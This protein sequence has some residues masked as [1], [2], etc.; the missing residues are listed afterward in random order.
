[1]LSGAASSF[2]DG[3]SFS[4]NSDMSVK[5]V[6]ENN[7]TEIPVGYE[8]IYNSYSTQV[9]KYINKTYSSSPVSKIL[10]SFA[11]NGDY[12]SEY[13]IKDGNEITNPLFR[14][15]DEYAKYVLNLS[16]PVCAIGVYNN[17]TQILFANFPGS[18]NELCGDFVGTTELSTNEEYT[19]SAEA[20]GLPDGAV[21]S[22][23][24][25]TFD[26]Y[27]KISG[28]SLMIEPVKLYCD[29]TA[30]MVM[31]TI[32]PRNNSISQ[33]GFK[34]SVSN[35]LTNTIIKNIKI[36]KIITGE[37]DCVK[38]LY[39]SE[40][41]YTELKG[42]SSVWTKITSCKLAGI[43]DC[44]R[45]SGTDLAVN[46]EN[47]ARATDGNAVIWYNDLGGAKMGSMFTPVE[48]NGT[49]SAMGGLEYGKVTKQRD[50]TV[51]TYA[52]YNSDGVFVKTTQNINRGNE[53]KICTT[54]QD[55]YGRT[56]RS[57][58]NKGVVTTYG[59]DEYGR[60]T[61]S[62]TT[63]GSAGTV[64]STCA[65]TG[66]V[67][68][69]YTVTETDG[70]GYSTV[71]KYDYA[72]GNVISVTD[73]NGN[74]IE[75]DYDSQQRLKEVAGRS[76]NVVNKNQ[77]QYTKDYISI[78]QH[79]GATYGITQTNGRVTSIML[80]GAT[81][82][83][84]DDRY[85]TEGYI[86]KT[87]GSQTQCIYYDKFGREI[88][89]KWSDGEWQTKI[90]GEITDE[91]SGITS[92]TDGSLNVTTASKLRK[93]L[94]GSENRVYN[95]NIDGTLSE[96]VYSNGD[97]Y[98]VTYDGYGRKSG[99]SYACDGT[100]SYGYAYENGDMQVTDKV[101]QV[102]IT[103]NGYFGAADYTYDALERLT[104]VKYRAALLANN[105]IE[106][107]YEY[108]A[109]SPE[110][111]ATERFY[112]NGALKTANSVVYDKNG[113]ITYYGATKY[114]YDTLNR[115]IREDNPTL[116]KSYVYAY[117][118]GGNI[119]SKK[120]YAYTTG[121]LGSA[122]KTSTYTY[123][124]TTHKDRLTSWAGKS[125]AYDTAGN[126]TTYKGESMTWKSG[127]L[128]VS[129]TKGGK[130]VEYAYDGEGIRKTKTVPSGNGFAEKY[131]YKYINDK[132]VEEK[133]QLMLNDSVLLTVK[134]QFMYAGDEVIGV[135]Y[136][137]KV[138][139]Y[140][141]NLQGDVIGIYDETGESVATYSYDAWGNI[142]TSSTS[143][144]GLDNPFRYRSYVYDTDTGLYYLNSRYYDPETCRFV[145]M[146][147][148]EYADPETINGLNLYAYCGN[149][150]V[151]NVDPTGSKW[152]EF[153][154]WDWEKIAATTL[155][156]IATVGAIALTVATLGATVGITICT[157][158]FAIGF[159]GSLFAQ[160]LAGQGF[161]IG[162]AFFD[163][164]WGII[165]I[166]GAASGIGALGSVFLGS[167][168]GG[169]QSVTSD[170]IFNNGKIDFKNL[171]YSVLGGA[172]G[173]LFAGAGAKSTIKAVQG[174]SQILKN[175]ISNGLKQ[176]IAKAFTVLSKNAFKLLQS[177][178][179]Y[180]FGIIVGQS[181]VLGGTT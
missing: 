32:R 59:Y 137:D 138:Y 95:Y 166:A 33:I 86:S 10:Y 173:G 136:G 46:K 169:L 67:N 71:Y 148:I 19:F 24:D 31:S 132:L 164:L 45:V 42:T 13:E 99:E 139:Y 41:K 68:G 106:T 60:R 131:T 18:T 25:I 91:V 23:K 66:N 12:I 161:N 61:S 100:I 6:T 52:T 35:G 127:R 145:N 160:S 69:V 97:R 75:Y 111:V 93:V 167:V 176:Y 7:G 39:G 109:T 121:T 115:L 157:I 171:F 55:T 20:S 130:T 144:I 152:W 54:E 83:T 29:S 134:M 62:K 155:T 158:G 49:V 116:G 73:A 168:I 143:G 8:L 48:I 128:L 170:Y 103:G 123:G 15:Q 84:A 34:I 94:D 47:L 98:S 16:S 36:G 74:T 2:G 37:T 81:L 89:S 28:E 159:S 22:I 53:F 43:S 124:N 40:I 72:T 85:A 174:A 92:A 14:S 113:N 3:V 64:S 153:W 179:L 87:I 21:G 107:S 96:I 63:S 178:G 142:S 150:P 133:K 119:T 27:D 154:K 77:I 172:I 118:S 125:Y 5:C 79:T 78:M 181:I 90:Y 114:T 105:S 177:A 162:K 70:A 30:K 4:Y 56:T 80:D 1:M 57:I 110:R 58:N 38:G 102:T 26:V 120:E 44:E 9:N 163:G 76:G 112:S 135:T 156:L 108:S 151:M 126:P 65:Y 88:R 175:T 117:D 147:G 11:E 141:K 104:G 101:K 82:M 180:L 140:R 129:Y 50:L 17:S 149:N 146:D 165:G 122:T 51:F